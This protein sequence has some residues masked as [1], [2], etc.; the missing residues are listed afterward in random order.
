V[1]CLYLRHPVD[2]YRARLQELLKHGDRPFP[3]EDSGLRQ[4]LLDTEAAFGRKAELMLFDRKVLA[5]G[6]IVQDFVTRFLGQ[7][8]DPPD[9]PSQDANVGF[10]AEALVLMSQLRAR[11]GRTREG[12]RRV[13]M[14]RGLLNQLDRQDPPKEPFTLLPEVAEAALRSASSYRWLAETGRLAIPGLDIGRIDGAPPPAWMMTAPPTALFRHD[15]ERLGRLGLAVENHLQQHGWPHDPSKQPKVNL[16][17]FLL[18]FLLGKLG[19]P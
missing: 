9:V 18:R 4:A 17:D 7:L 16:R 15:P 3:P 1:P 13:E 14:L 12:I 10:S 19:S 6:D 5:G 11:S 2:H 8:V